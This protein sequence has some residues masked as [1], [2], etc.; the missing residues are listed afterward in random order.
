MTIPRLVILNAYWQKN[1]P[2]H[3]AA[4]TVRLMMEA[5]LG[6]EQPVKELEQQ[7]KL[8]EIEQAIP[9]KK[10]PVAE[11]DAMLAKIKTEI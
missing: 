3:L 10:L 4:N 9:V 7:P 1:P 11:F 8:E 6:V 2:T 5:Y